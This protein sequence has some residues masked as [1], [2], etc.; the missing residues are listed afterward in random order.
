MPLTMPRSTAQITGCSI[1]AV[2]ERA[3]LDTMRS[4]L[5]CSL[6]VGGEAVGGEGVGDRVQRGAE[7]ALAVARVAIAAAIVRP[8]STPTSSAIC[9]GLRRAAAARAPGRAG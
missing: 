1:A 4:S 2:A 7:R 6:G 3:V 5:P 9:L 8:Y